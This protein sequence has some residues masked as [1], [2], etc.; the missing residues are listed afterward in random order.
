MFTGAPLRAL[1]VPAI[2]SGRRA[3]FVAVGLGLVA[4]AACQSFNEP[5][6]P[7]PPAPSTRPQPQ[8][9]PPEQ[10]PEPPAPPQPPVKH[11]RLSA[12]SSALVSQAHTQVKSGD[13]VA[14][15]ATLERALR[16]EPGNPLLWIELGRLR[17]NEDNPKQ[18]D[19]MGRK[20]L[21][22]ATGD[23]NTQAAAWQ[24]IAESLRA[25][26]LNQ[27]AAEAEAHADALLAP[28]A[29]DYNI[30]APGDDE[31]PRPF[32]KDNKGFWGIGV[33]DSDELAII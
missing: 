8:T 15:A 22:L 4:L 14:A 3:R 17:L 32:E 6:P 30:P 28:L 9:P 13:T 2:R 24:L 20:A 33:E 26:R 29:D 16:I 27:E 12:A 23:R 25:R 7:Q 18:A 19:S 31:G 5:L 21:A 1:I 11:F 10:V